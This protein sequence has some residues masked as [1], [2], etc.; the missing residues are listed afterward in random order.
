MRF[1]A[2][3]VHIERVFCGVTI[4]FVRR[5]YVNH[6]VFLQDSE[7]IAR[8][9]ADIP[10]KQRKR[11]LEFGHVMLRANSH[12]AWCFSDY[13]LIAQPVEQK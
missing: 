12:A 7:D 1:K 6:D 11:F 8:C 9:I 3:R 10:R 4:T 13:E 2:A 5:G